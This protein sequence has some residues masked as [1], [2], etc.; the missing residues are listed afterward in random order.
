MK[1]VGNTLEID[2]AVCCITCPMM[3][4]TTS[5]RP[6]GQVLQSDQIHSNPFQKCFGQPAR[7]RNLSEPL[8]S[9]QIRH[10]ST[11]Q[12]AC[13]FR[14]FPIRS[15]LLQSFYLGSLCCSKEPFRSVQFC[16]NLSISG[17]IVRASCDFDVAVRLMFGWP[18]PQDGDLM[19]TVDCNTCDIQLYA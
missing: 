19:I 11:F 4:P 13:C 15:V 12:A 8:K 9:V 14:D 16:C 18:S 1:A 5:G 17:T 2:S 10:I 7:A 6:P 3:D